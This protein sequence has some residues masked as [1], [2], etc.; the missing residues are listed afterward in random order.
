MRPPQENLQQTHK[1]F[2]T[3]MAIWSY[4]KL[5]EKHEAFIRLHKSL[6]MAWAKSVALG[7]ATLQLV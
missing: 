1:E 7:E 4:I 3:D 5:G 6:N 2:K